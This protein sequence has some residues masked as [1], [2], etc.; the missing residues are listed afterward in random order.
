M[1]PW[2][3]QAAAA[4]TDIMRELASREKLQV[5]LFAAAFL[6]LAPVLYYSLTTP[7]AL[8]D[9]YG[10]WKFVRILDSP[11]QFFDWLHLNFLDPDADR[12]WPLREFYDAV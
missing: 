5:A 12:F 6:L 10:R 1:R 9:D 3:R 7:F 2:H 4:P 8:I 11:E